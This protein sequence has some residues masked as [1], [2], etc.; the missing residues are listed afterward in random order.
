[1]RWKQKNTAAAK[2]AA[3]VKEF[4]LLLRRSGTVEDVDVQVI[5]RDIDAVLCEALA[6]GFIEAAERVPVI[7]AG[8]PAADGVFDGAVAVGAEENIGRG[9]IQYAGGGGHGI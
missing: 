4:Y 9:L 7:G 2:K 6:Q 8:C 3:A 5:I 1:M